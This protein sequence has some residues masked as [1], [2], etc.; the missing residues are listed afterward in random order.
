MSVG[1]PA[2]PWWSFKEALIV[3][4]DM[5][6]AYGSVLPQGFGN[7]LVVVIQLILFC[8]KDGEIQEKLSPLCLIL[9]PDVKDLLLVVVLLG[10]II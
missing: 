7:S 10:R 8:N 1:Q 6:L 2:V 4:R 3:F 9:K 5:L